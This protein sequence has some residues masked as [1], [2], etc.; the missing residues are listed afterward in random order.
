LTNGEYEIIAVNINQI[1]VIKLTNQKKMEYKSYNIIEEDEVIITSDNKFQKVIYYY[2]QSNQIQY[3]IEKGI[4]LK[5]EIK[6]VSINMSPNKTMMIVYDVN[7]NNLILK[8]INKESNSLPSKV[9]DSFLTSVDGIDLLMMIKYLINKKMFNYEEFK[10]NLKIMINSENKNSFYYEKYKKFLNLINLILNERNDMIII[11]F[12]IHIILIDMFDTFTN[13]KLETKDIEKMNVIKQIIPLVNWIITFGYFLLILK[14]DHYTK[15]SKMF[16]SDNFLSDKVVEKLSDLLAK[17]NESIGIYEKMANNFDYFYKL[18]VTI[19]EYNKIRKTYSELEKIN[20]QE[21][22]KFFTNL[23]LIKIKK[24]ENFK[25]TQYFN[26][27]NVQP[28]I[29]GFISNN[30]ENLSLI[31]TNYENNF[32]KNSKNYD[33]FSFLIDDLLSKVKIPKNEN[34]KACITCNRVTLINNSDLFSKKWFFVCPICNSFWKK[35]N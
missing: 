19:E 14:K 1:E 4:K 17:L 16:F 32:F 18:V 34:I 29:S 15:G 8:F 28:L 31:E 24:F 30:Y 10:Y 6:P 23:E 3:D 13:T 5:K 9:V 35:I 21:K 33:E 22:K 26:Y 25:K 7:E 12:N 11:E 2:K 27:L 20:E